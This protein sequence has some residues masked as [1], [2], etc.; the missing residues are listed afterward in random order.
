MKKKR[1]IPKGFSDLSWIDSAIKNSGK[2][3]RKLKKAERQQTPEEKRLLRDLNVANIYI[4]TVKS[5]KRRFRA[6]KHRDE[7][8][9][10]L[11]RLKH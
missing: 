8:I 5:K 7:I 6:I 11:K 4:G 10:K 3:L 9:K 1:F 2:Q